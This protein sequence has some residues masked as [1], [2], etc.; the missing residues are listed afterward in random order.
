MLW[1]L[2]RV[3]IFHWEIEEII[4]SCEP[5]PWL[6]DRFAAAV[7]NAALITTVGHL[8]RVNILRCNRRDHRQLWTMALVDRQIRHDLWPWSTDRFTMAVL[9]A[10][11]ITAIPLLAVYIQL[12]TLAFSDSLRR[13]DC[14]RQQCSPF[15]P[16]GLKI[17][18]YVMLRAREIKCPGYFLFWRCVKDGLA[19]QSR[20][21]TINIVVD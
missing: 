19:W 13:N 12:V 14:E 3:N 1:R 7:L 21:R 20:D 2:P 6:T 4:A 5:W 18:C 8:Y 9:N 16:C 10:A 11:L 15:I 17:P